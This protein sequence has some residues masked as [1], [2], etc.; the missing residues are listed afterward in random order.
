LN[1]SAEQIGAFTDPAILS[2]GFRPFFLFGA[3]WAGER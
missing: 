2:F 1:T 3:L